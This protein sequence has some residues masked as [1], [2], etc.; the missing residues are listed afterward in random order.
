M[1]AHRSSCV[2]RLYQNGPVD[3]VDVLVLVLQSVHG[4]G[5]LAPSAPFEGRRADP[6]TAA[7]HGLDIA[8]WEYLI[9]MLLA[10]RLLLLTWEG[11]HS[12][13]GRLT[14]FDLSAFVVLRLESAAILGVFS[15]VSVSISG[16]R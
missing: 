7:A 11:H 12:R 9:A 6:A 2:G 15:K 10:L 3:G 5:A 13:T 16:L 1:C 14:V 8:D 4:T